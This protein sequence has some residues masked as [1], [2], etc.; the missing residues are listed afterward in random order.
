MYI[1]IF[2]SRTEAEIAKSALT[3]RHI[4]SYLDT[5]DAGGMVPS[6]PEGVRLYVKKGDALKAKELLHI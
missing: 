3:A 4:D 2:G 1:K 5:D 6:L